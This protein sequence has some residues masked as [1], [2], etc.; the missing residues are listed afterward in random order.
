M[1]VVNMCRLRETGAQLEWQEEELRM[2]DEALRQ[3]RIQH[4]LL[5]EDSAKARVEEWRRIRDEL[6]KAEL[7]RL[8]R[9][10]AVYLLQL[11]AECFTECRE[12]ILA[13]ERL[14]VKQQLESEEKARMAVER[15]RIRERL[16][17][18]LQLPQPLAPFQH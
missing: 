16:M 7:D 10:E 12:R 15:L 14:A 9:E 18:V 13:E 8:R 1:V 5:Q 11:K 3:D 4:A 17:Q 6:I 2:L